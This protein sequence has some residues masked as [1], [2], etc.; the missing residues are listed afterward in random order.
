MRKTL[1]KITLGLITVLS[2]NNTYAQ[3]TSSAETPLVEAKK[4]SP[5]TIGVDLVSAYVWRGT[6]YSGPSVQP[7]LEYGIGGFS[8]GSWGSFDFV[9]GFNEVDTYASYSFEFGL[10]LG[11]TDYYYQGSR[12]F[13]FADT[14]G[15]HAFEANLNYAISGFTASANYVIN[16]THAGGPGS[17]GGDMYYQVGYGF[18]YFE[19]FVGA[20]DGW[21]TSDGNF[22]VCNIGIGVTKE[23]KINELFSIPIFGQIIINPDR[24]EYDLVVGI[25]I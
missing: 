8:I 2:V 18:K 21:H 6:K 22:N 4:E 14:T 12:A 19:V 9:N 16:D 10:S 24:S 23:I 1:L 5:F 17:N 13:D 7:T 3:E 11:L 15:S 20:G 25:S